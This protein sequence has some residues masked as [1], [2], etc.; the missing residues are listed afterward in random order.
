MDMDSNEQKI[1]IADAATHDTYVEMEYNANLSIFFHAD[2]IRQSRMNGFLSMN[3]FLLAG[4]GLASNGNMGEASQILVLIVCL[5][6]LIVSRAMKLSQSRNDEFLKFR[7]YQL[8]DLEAKMKGVMTFSNSKQAFDEGEFVF[9]NSNEKYV[10]N[11]RQRY[12]S[13]QIDRFVMDVISAVW[14]IALLGILGAY[15]AGAIGNEA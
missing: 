14:F 5:V 3:A 10:S 2:S 12:N 7:R 1:A 6:G 8:R 15:L 13:G 9:P 11:T 4:V